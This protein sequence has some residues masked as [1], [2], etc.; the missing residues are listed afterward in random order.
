M[1]KRYLCEVAA[2][3]FLG[4]TFTSTEAFTAFEEVDFKLKADAGEIYTEEW[5]NPD[6]ESNL[7]LIHKT[8]R[9]SGL[10][11]IDNF[12]VDSQANELSWFLN[13]AMA[14]QNWVASRFVPQSKHPIYFPRQDLHLQNIERY[15]NN[16]LEYH[17]E[18]IFSFAFDRTHVEHVTH[19]DSCE[20][21]LCYYEKFVLTSPP[22]DRF[23]RKLTGRP[24]IVDGL[25]AF[26]FKKVRYHN[27]LT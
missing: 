1:P 5:I 25:A 13:E 23:L 18:D 8:F 4:S 11:T 2:L 6:V 27:I 15:Y 19:E 16:S 24:M 7:H 20:C 12:L 10:I 17:K 22:I 9:D 14:E 21:Y 3:C 26:R